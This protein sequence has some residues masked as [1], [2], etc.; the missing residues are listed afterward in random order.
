MDIAFG[1]SLPTGATEEDP[2][3]AADAGLNHEHIQ[4]GT[5]TFDPLLELYYTAPLSPSFTLSAFG[6]GRFPFYE[7]SKTYEGPT[8][9]TTGLNLLYGVNSRLTLQSTLTAYY[10]GFAHWD[11]DRDINS[12]LRSLLGRL[13]ATF[14]T[15]R[16]TALN[17]SVQQ[18]IT[19]ETLD[20]K[21]DTF[22]QGPSF[23]FYVSHSFNP[24]SSTR[25][26]EAL[27]SP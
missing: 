4:F 6:V 8:E 1:T 23:L 15:K 11:G 27:A 20:K 3:K 2:F 10:Q 12:G 19:Q 25:D 5:G 24:K 14:I 22:G 26:P 18:P 21:G 16:G 13:G 9:V 17:I 7:N